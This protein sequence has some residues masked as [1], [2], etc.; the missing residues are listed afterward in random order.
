MRQRFD[1]PG[2]LEGTGVQ[3]FN[4][5]HKL[6]AAQAGNGVAFAHGR[7]QTLADLYEQHIALLMAQ[8]V[9]DALEIVQIHEHQGPVVAGLGTGFDGMLQAIEQQTA[10]GQLG[11]RVVKR[12][13]A[14]FF[15]GRFAAGN[16]KQRTDV[17]GGG[18]GLVFDGGNGQPLGVDFTV[19]AAIPD[20][21]RPGAVAEQLLAHGS[22][23]R[24]TMPT[25]FQDAGAFAHHICGAVAGDVGKGLVD[26]Q[27]AAFGIGDDHAL[28]RFK[29]NGG[30]A[31]LF[32]G[33]F[34]LL[35]VAGKQA[36]RPARKHPRA[37]PAQQQR[38]QHDQH[39]LQLQLQL[40]LLA[41]FVL[42]LL[43]DFS[44][45]GRFQLVVEHGGGQHPA[46]RGIG[47]DQGGFAPQGGIGCRPRTGPVV[48]DK[49]ATALGR[50]AQ[51]F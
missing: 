51:L 48:F 37:Q 50:L 35:V 8:D 30:D 36:P 13:V 6:I 19:F 7:T 28:L 47:G 9:I 3:A 46:P 14:N 4:E 49:A 22:I 39:Q 27:D 15:L 41:R 18:L 21:S 40:Q 2:G 26:L 24:R 44:L 34:A 16:V 17:M 29:G 20:L 32:L 45:P 5:Q 42:V 1:L 38:G 12:Q 33:G 43:L 31:Q 11:Q 25:R 10:I 23:K